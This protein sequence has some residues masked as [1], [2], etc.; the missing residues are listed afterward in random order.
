MQKTALIL[1]PTGRFGR[2]TATALKRH[3]WTVRA[4]NRATDTL[5]DTA[6]GTDLI[7]N[8]WNP[9]YSDWAAQVPGLTAQVID[10]A[11]TSGA[12]VLIPGNIY[13]FGEDI[14][15]IIGP[16][17]PH[18]ATHPL[19]RIRRNMEDAYRSSGV[20]TLILRSGDYIDTEISANWLHKIIIADLAKGRV[21]YPGPMDRPHAWAYLPDVG[22][23]AA[24]LANRLDD[25]PTFSDFMFDGYT[26]TGAEL[27]Q[28]VEATTGQRLKTKPMSW[29][30]IHLAR[31]FWAEAKHLVEMRYLWNR[32]HRA[33][34]TKLAEIIPNLSQTTVPDA[35]AV[36]CAPLSPAARDRLEH[37]HP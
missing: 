30:P 12:A 10:A 6:L 29:L 1:G 27:A 25:L 21:R 35:L 34:G 11:K 23:T 4:F 22:E 9:L 26:L 8:G 5:P 32:P 19:G 16:N 33:D 17:T 13:V 18:R 3:G 15:A 24:H 37:V 7:V 2:H 31:P 28:A 36:A 20:K 14:P